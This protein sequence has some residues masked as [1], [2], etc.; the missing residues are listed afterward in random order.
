MCPVDDTPV[1]WSPNALRKGHPSASDGRTSGGEAGR[2]LV[3]NTADIGIRYAPGVCS[4]R[5]RPTYRGG[6]LV[7]SVASAPTGK[8]VAAT[9]T[10]D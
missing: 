9:I 3:G 7:C 8:L 2:S 4:C 1:D 6:P 5:S 10:P